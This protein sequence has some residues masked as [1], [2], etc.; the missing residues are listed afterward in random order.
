M[1]EYLTLP[2]ALDR[3][4]PQQQQLHQQNFLRHPQQLT[5]INQHDFQRIG[6]ASTHTIQPAVFPRQFTEIIPDNIQAASAPIQ[7]TGRS[8]ESTGIIRTSNTSAPPGYDEAKARESEFNELNARFET[9]KKK[10]LM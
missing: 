3:P 2:V 5:E 6:M 10:K 4:A 9:L 7:D 8:S 1:G